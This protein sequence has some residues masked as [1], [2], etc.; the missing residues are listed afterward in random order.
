MAKQRIDLPLL[1][2]D[3]PDVRDACV[4]RLQA[5]LTPRRGVLRTHV[6]GRDGRPELCVHYDPALISGE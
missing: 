6:R 4:A 3:L 2:P 5:L 1:L